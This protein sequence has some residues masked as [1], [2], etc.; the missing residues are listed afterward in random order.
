MPNTQKHIWAY[1]AFQ[2]NKKISNEYRYK[3]DLKIE[4]IALLTKSEADFRKKK[5]NQG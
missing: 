3:G 1:S 2:L 5:P 4:C